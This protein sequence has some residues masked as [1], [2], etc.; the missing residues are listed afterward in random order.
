MGRMGDFLTYL[1]ST[2]CMNGRKVIAAAVSEG[3]E[4]I[5]RYQKNLEKLRRK[6]RLL[7]IMALSPLPRHVVRK[8]VQECERYEDDEDE[9]TPEERRELQIEAEREQAE[10]HEWLDLWDDEIRRQQR[11]ERGQ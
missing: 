3:I 2:D 7:I 6:Q 10:R 9:L 4:D 5:D 1:A 8:H 11:R